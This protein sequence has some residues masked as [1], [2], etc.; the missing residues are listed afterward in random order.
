MSGDV[1]SG[2]L[3]SGDET[4]ARGFPAFAA[5]RGS[6]ARGRSWWG[7]AWAD[8]L[9][10]TSLDEESLK[11]G[12]AYARTGRL[13][14]I[15]VSPGR[16]STTGYEGDTPFRTVLTLEELDDAEWESL[17]EKTAE[18]PDATDELLAG[19]LPP[20]L[21]E[22]AEDARVRLLPGYGDL[23]AECDCGAFDHPCKHA[24][25][26]C[27]QASWLLD[28]DT[29]LLLLLRG[30]GA[31]EAQEELRSV[32]LMQAIV[33][34]LGDGDGDGDADGAEA[35]AEA[36]SQAAAAQLPDGTP[37]EEV[38]GREPAALPE[39]PPLPG[40]PVRQA[41]SS[42]AAGADPLEQ[43]VTG[44]AV[45]ARE[46]LAYALGFTAEPPAPLDLWRDCVRIAA[47]RPE[48]R[49]L[50]RLREA[51]GSPDRLD[52]AAEAWRLGGSA[53][54]DVLEE[55]WTPPQQDTARARTALTAGWEQDEL[56]ELEVRDN[57]FTPAGSGL[58]LRY[59]RDGRWYPY[60]QRDGRWW[61]AAAPH[62]DPAEVL[63]ELLDDRG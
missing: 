42:A 10:G 21:L 47:T 11:K 34:S 7:K 45:R 62:H 37:A 2:D 14:P 26:L 56:P 60:R 15:T 23:E 29:M 63:A 35:E 39:L 49:V 19:E 27:Y 31:Q 28:E 41:V 52:R 43:L 33:G 61:P 30:R 36:G 16:I 1:T 17:W 55:A 38:F 50:A 20:D 12:R 44:A 51:C 22:A 25:A 18:R 57:S 24:A 32:L 58:Q 40:P 53:G 13:G 3:R 54:L 5:R 9:E 48:P 46:L 8:A 4:G 59:G 6:R